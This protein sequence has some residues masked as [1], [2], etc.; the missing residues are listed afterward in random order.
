M[1]GESLL[2]SHVAQSLL[3]GVRDPSTSTATPAAR[4]C[5]RLL[6]E[7]TRAHTHEGTPGQI[8]R[9]HIQA[10]GPNREDCRPCQSRVNRRFM[11]SK[12]LLTKTSKTRAKKIIEGFA[13]SRRRYEF[14]V[15]SVRYRRTFFKEHNAR[16][17]ICRQQHHAECLVALISKESSF[18]NVTTCILE[19]IF[20]N[21]TQFL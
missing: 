8:L 7:E 2:T 21:F 14:V 9:A 4:L 5:R 18:E 19:E 12:G 10:R 11:A 20:G 15:M 17:Y 6:P 13:N 16:A 1:P 3:P